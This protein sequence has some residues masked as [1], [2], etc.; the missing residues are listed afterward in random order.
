[1]AV[2][3]VMT[4][5]SFLDTNPEDFVTPENS[6]KTEAD[7]KMALNGIYATL[8]ETSLYGNNMLGRMGLSADLGYESYSTDVGTVGDYDVSP[9]DAKILAYW[10]ELYDGIN[11][12]NLL[13]ENI[14]R[15]DIEEKLRDSYLGQALFL[16]AY[17]YWMLVVRFNNIPLILETAKDNSKESL[18]I[19]QSSPREVYLQIIAD[20]EKATPL[21]PV[22]TEVE[23]PCRVSQSAVYALLSKVCLYMAGYPVK[24]PGMYE[25]A[26]KYAG[27]VISSGYHSLITECNI[28]Y[29][30]IYWADNA[31]EEDKTYVP[32]YRSGFMQV[33]I[34]YIQD[35]YNK[36]ES[37]FEVN[38]YGNNEGAY[39]TTAGMVG[40]NNGIY[41]QTNS[42][43]RDIVG[44]SIG[45]IRTTPYY[46][47]MFGEGDLR[48][49]WTIADFVY[50]MN[51]ETYEGTQK[52]HPATEIW[53]RHCGK[54]RREYE[55]SSS[56]SVTHTS[57][58]FPI[59]RYADILMV[60]AEA[61][62]CDQGSTGAE[63]EQAW[64]YLNQ[65]RRRGYG[66]PVTEASAEAD[67]DEGDGALMDI[68]K[69]ERARELGFELTRKDDLV[70][71]GIFWDNMK[72][73]K[74]LTETTIKPTWT[75]DY[76][77]YAKAYFR[78]V[79][80]RDEFWPIPTYEMGV[81][82]KLVQN[83][84]W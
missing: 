76:Y 10:R 25:K 65:V 40:R 58:N 33:F 16:R 45:A 17:Y 7:V 69:D 8:A 35:L 34:N 78:N 73:L 57:I 77:T 24:E 4:S 82:R 15:A 63:L 68:L 49:D 54:F 43:L 62:A 55:A 27:E 13:I 1:M 11:R 28:E 48:R 75:A 47:E 22:I 31:T 3:A 41:I 52:I 81:N 56:K 59:L 50:K 21:V 29:K 53:V 6:Y 72:H 51:S 80:Q 83:P 18:Q 66:K 2:L 23:S 9:S 12:A 32:N 14:D 84:G 26:K 19:A 64:E 39:T 20:L 74:N 61:V 5:C 71:W 30:P 67:L 46:F 42:S 44:Y 60:W 38:F 70:R 36:Q 37:I 79:S